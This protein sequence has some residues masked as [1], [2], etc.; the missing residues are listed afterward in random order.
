MLDRQRRAPRAVRTAG[1]RTIGRP[2]FWR[3]SCGA[4][5]REDARAN[6]RLTRAPEKLM[7]GEGESFVGCCYGAASAELDSCSRCSATFVPSAGS[8]DRA[9]S[10]RELAGFRT[11]LG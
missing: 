6:V 8:T 3:P 11:V 7:E 2:L 5:T 4:P 9:E 10:G 1:G